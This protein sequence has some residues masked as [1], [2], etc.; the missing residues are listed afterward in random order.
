MFLAVPFF[1]EVL[2]LPN[3]E[4][5]TDKAWRKTSLPPY[6]QMPMKLITDNDF[7]GVNSNGNTEYFKASPP[8][9]LHKKDTDDEGTSYFSHCDRFLCMSK[10]K[11]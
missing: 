2:F 6:R 10:E 3:I 8:H 4:K 1:S 11:V 5:D 7:P 9:E